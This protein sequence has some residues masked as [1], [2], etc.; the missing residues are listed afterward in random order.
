MEII[1]ICPKDKIMITYQE[2]C[3]ID[4]VRQ[5]NE[6]FSKSFPDNI[7]IGNFS[8]IVKDITIF[9]ECENSTTPDI[10]EGN[11]NGYIY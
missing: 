1:N 6:Y 2:D 11:N 9:R 7:I 3:D 10:M 5:I 8:G 4:T